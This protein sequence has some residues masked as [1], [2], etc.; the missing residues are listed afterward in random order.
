MVSWESE[1]SPGMPESDLCDDDDDD[2][3]DEDDD[4]DDDD[5]DDIFLKP[6]KKS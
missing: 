5:D 3:E 2:D 1:P 6:F 4:D